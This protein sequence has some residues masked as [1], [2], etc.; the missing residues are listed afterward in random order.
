MKT[1]E[2]KQVN[3]LVE[4]LA[5]NEKNELSTFYKKIRERLAKEKLHSPSSFDYKQ[6]ALLMKKYTSL[7]I[8]DIAGAKKALIKVRE[9]LLP[10]TLQERKNQVLQTLLKANFPN[11]SLLLEKSLIEFEAG[12]APVEVKMYKLIGGYIA[13]ITEALDIYIALDN[14][15]KAT[16]E[17]L[18]E[19]VLSIHNEA[20][21][22]LFYQEEK[23]VIAPSLEKT[24]IVYA[25]VYFHICYLGKNDAPKT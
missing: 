11:H 3:Y 8:K 14:E 18:K 17:S 1:K 19:Y 25:G 16:F 15:K 6:I 22:I 4:Y 13:S 5:L 24:A 12:L 10:K 9:A 7:N 21:K 20:M 23:D 2:L